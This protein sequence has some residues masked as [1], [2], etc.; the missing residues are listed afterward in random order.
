[1][2]FSANEGEG[3]AIHGSPVKSTSQKSRGLQ[4]SVHSPVEEVIAA[5][6]RT[7]EKVKTD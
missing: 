1:M 2:L 3:P 5:Q 6:R 7:K 4:A